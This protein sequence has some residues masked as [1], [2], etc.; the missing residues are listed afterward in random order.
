[1]QWSL[2]V[3]PLFYDLGRTSRYTKKAFYLQLEK[4]ACEGTQKVSCSKP[5]TFRYTYPKVLTPEYHSRDSCNGIQTQRNWKSLLL[6]LTW[7]IWQLPYSKTRKSGGRG[8]FSIW[9]SVFFMQIPSATAR[10][11]CLKKPPT[12]KFGQKYLPKSE[13]EDSS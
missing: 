13:I 6:C 1:M 11:S 7:R 2:A 10:G 12:L 4:E 5:R 3:S 9:A 8:V